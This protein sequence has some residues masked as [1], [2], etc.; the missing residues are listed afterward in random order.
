VLLHLDMRAFLHEHRVRGLTLSAWLRSVVGARSTVFAWEDPRPAGS[1]LARM[2]RT[3][4]PGRLKARVR[5]L[6]RGG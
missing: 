4:L 1:L 3:R 2:V 6:Q 5:R